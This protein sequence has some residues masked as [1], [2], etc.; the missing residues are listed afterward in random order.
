[1][2]LCASVAI[3]SALAALSLASTRLEERQRDK[4]YT[5]TC[6]GPRCTEYPA[7]STKLPTSIP[8]TSS[9]PP[10]KTSTRPL[11]PTKTQTE[12]VGPSSTRCP[13]PLYYQCGGYYDG[14]PW[15][16]CTKCVS[17]AKCVWQNEWYY[18]CV[19]DED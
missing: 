12:E 2:K 9:K 18:Q 8:K 14:K 17:G 3:L 11:P 15:T 6:I 4:T 19:A 7:T 13:V 1:M 10:T 16:G 5:I